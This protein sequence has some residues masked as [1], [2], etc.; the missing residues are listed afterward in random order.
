MLSNDVMD[1]SN[2]ILLLKPIFVKITRNCR[3]SSRFAEMCLLA[4]EMFNKGSQIQRFLQAKL[5]FRLRTIW[6][7]YHFFLCAWTFRFSHLFFCRTITEHKLLFSVQC[8]QL[9]ISITSLLACLRCSVFLCMLSVLFFIRFCAWQTMH[10][11]IPLFH[12][13]AYLLVIS[14]VTIPLFG[15]N[16][17]TFSYVALLIANNNC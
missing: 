14:D 17:K 5:P 10:D 12:C 9:W 1:V 2:I 16:C 3:R 6:N 8:A 4:T 15:A 11:Y 7:C 13:P